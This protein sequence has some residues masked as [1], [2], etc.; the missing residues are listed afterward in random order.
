MDLVRRL[1]GTQKPLAVK[2]Y[3]ARGTKGDLQQRAVHRPRQN[4]RE[5]RADTF[6]PGA[7]KPA[8]PIRCRTSKGCVFRG[9][10]TDVAIVSRSDPTYS[11]PAAVDRKERSSTRNIAPPTCRL[12]K[13][14]QS[15]SWPVLK[16]LSSLLK[17]Y[18]N[19][20]DSPDNSQER[21]CSR[22]KRSELYA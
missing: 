15:N 13:M 3:R 14:P 10:S 11:I 1:T 16:L 7:R 6:E 21:D 5:L 20:A 12:R 19:C 4:G 9:L 2:I 22:H 17:R 8:D 18:L